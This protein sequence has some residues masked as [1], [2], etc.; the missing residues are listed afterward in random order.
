MLKKMHRMSMSSRAINLNS[1]DLLSSNVISERKRE[2]P[3]YDSPK[4]GFDAIQEKDSEDSDFQ[5]KLEED[6]NI[7]SSI[8]SYSKSKDIKG[9]GTTESSASLRR[10]E[11]DSEHGLNRPEYDLTKNGIK[12]HNSN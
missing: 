7:H 10:A 8:K 2:I 6:A 11:Y 5:S 9:S 4:K 1:F 12:K 3:K